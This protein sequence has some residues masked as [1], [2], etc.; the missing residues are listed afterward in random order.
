[1]RFVRYA[2]GSK[3]ELGIG[4]GS[5]KIMPI[6]EVCRYLDMEPADSLLQ[7]IDTW[8]DAMV[9]RACEVATAHA[10]I[11]E[12]SLQL[13]APIPWPR[14]NVFCLGKNYLEH[15]KE[16]EGQTAN[17]SGV[18]E[19]PIY[20][21]KTASPAIGPN[22]PIRMFQDITHG[23]VD[24]EVELA[25][26]IGKKGT[27]IPAERAEEYVFG[28]TILNDISVRYLQTRHTQWFRGKCMDS[29]TVIGPA[30]VH[31]TAIAFPPKLRLGT[32]VNGEDRQNSTTDLMIFDIPTII[33][34]LSRG[35]TLY[36]GD[37]IATG[38]PSGVGMGFKPPRYLKDGDLVDCWI[39]GLGSLKNPVA[40]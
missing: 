22:D 34:D 31:R 14:R 23:E 28:Y 37:I 25:V 19:Y 38:T 26:I 40:P 5:G 39:E 12:E 27:D 7:I 9:A 1:M 13:L 21:T 2:G 11:P 17:L 32:R 3:P 20:F 29:H 16:L 15:A 30:V 10:S 36:P 18:P 8:N 4:D 6:A 24:Y 33:S 35:T